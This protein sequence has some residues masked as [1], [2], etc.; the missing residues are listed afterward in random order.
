MNSIKSVDFCMD[1]SIVAPV[2][3][4]NSPHYTTNTGIELGKKVAKELRDFL[5]NFNLFMGVTKIA[6]YRMDA[7][8]DENNLNILEINAS[9][10]DGWG[11]AL[12]LSRASGATVNSQ[13]LLFPNLFVN[14]EQVYAPEFKLCQEELQIAGAKRM[15]ESTD[16]LV[17][18]IYYYGRW[19]TK[20]D[21]IFPYDGIRMDNKMNLAMFSRVWQ[22][23]YIKIPK[24][25]MRGFDSWENI[26]NEVVLKF[27]DKGGEECRMARQS[28]IFNKPTGK[29]KFI[30]RCYE[31]DALI[32]Q[33]IIQP[34]KRGDDNCQ[35][36]I[37]AINEDP[38]TGYVQYSPKK[39]IND[40]SLHGPLRIIF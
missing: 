11:T 3:Y 20:N 23:N 35:L 33:E 25:Y 34:A 19:P 27:C 2:I 12:N 21:G 28:V 29:A 24:H 17:P 36:V 15:H 1:Q 6:Y 9:F 8:F 5:R 40:N 32:A 7:Y 37:L 22:G 4:G 38:V 18:T 26:P 16:R 30:K 14:E 10:V 31:K 39:I 13:S